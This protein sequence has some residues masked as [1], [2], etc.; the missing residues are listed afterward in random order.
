MDRRDF[1]AHINK[2]TFLLTSAAAGLSLFPA[3]N[4][5][6]SFFSLPDSRLKE[7]YRLRE[8]LARAQSRIP[9]PEHPV[10]GDEQLYENLIANFSKGLPANDLGEVDKKAYM[11]LKHA[12]TTGRPGD[13][14]KIP[15]GGPLRLANPQAALAWQLDGADSHHLGI[16]PPPPFASEEQAGELVELYWHALARDVPFSRYGKEPITRAAID[17]L[18]T[19][20]RYEGIDENSLFRGETADVKTGP[21]LSQFLWMTIPYGSQKIIQK[22]N[23]P[24]AGKNFMTDADECLRIQRGAESRDRIIHAAST[25]YVRTG[26]DMGEWVHSDYA[27]QGFLN[28]GLILVSFGDDALKPDHPYRDSVNQMGATTLGG[29]EILSLVAHAANC[30]QKAAWYQKWLL[31]RRIR[32]EAYGLR[33]HNHVTGRAKYP[34]HEKL[35]NSV[36]LEKIHSMTGNYVLPMAYPEGCPAHPSYPAAHA[37]TVGACMTILKAFFDEDFIFPEPVEAYDNGFT[38]RAYRGGDL[39]VGGELN[40]LAANI[41][42]ARD[43]AGLHWRSDSMNGIKLGEQVALRLLMD[44]QHTYNEK[45]RFSLTLTD[46][47]KVKI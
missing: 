45:F 34:I 4:A 32:P 20:K 16:Q 8:K 2:S 33:V 40:K 3:Q 28:A 31:H 29:P 22:Y 39:R 18:K 35:L 23:S 37:V 27:F 21:Y 30:A 42:L 9:V 46:G 19:F 5:T 6:A 26:R 13:F 25:R 44:Q 14:D 43:F 24:L 47:T 1:L 41:A 38:L 36:A 10:N 7:A 12:L 11:Q 15:M 17:E